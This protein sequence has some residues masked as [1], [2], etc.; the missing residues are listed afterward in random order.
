MVVREEVECWGV[1]RGMDGDERIGFV[2]VKIVRGV[3]GMSV[4][5]V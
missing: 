5:E 1:I 3:V 2:G 4:V